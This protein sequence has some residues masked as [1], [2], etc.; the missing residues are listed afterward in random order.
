MF[1]TLAITAVCILFDSIKIFE[2]LQMNQIIFVDWPCSKARFELV[3]KKEIKA[4]TVT[5][6]CTHRVFSG[7]WLH[8]ILPRGAFPIRD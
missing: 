7:R 8:Q 1:T 4:R 3:H 2:G 6:R 5:R